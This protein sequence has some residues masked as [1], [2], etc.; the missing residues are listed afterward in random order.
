M[1][2]T[3]SHLSTEEL[4]VPLH[5]SDDEDEF[6]YDDEDGYELNQL[7]NRISVAD[8]WNRMKFENETDRTGDGSESPLE[9]G[10]LFTILCRRFNKLKGNSLTENLLLT[11]IFG[12]LSSIPLSDENPYTY[13]L[14]AFM[15]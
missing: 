15:Y 11:S 8:S 9:S 10:K 1:Y 2:D 3:E 13:Y 6:I 7:T 5:D 4:Q 14:H 12:K